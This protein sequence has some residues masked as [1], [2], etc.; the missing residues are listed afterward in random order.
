R[1][2]YCRRFGA[3]VVCCIP[4]CG[5]RFHFPC[6][7]ASGCFQDMKTLSLLCPEHIDQ[8]E[9]IYGTSACCIQCG[10]VG[11][12]REQ[13]FCTIC[14]H[15]SHGSCL[16]MPVESKPISRSGWQCPNCK[17]CQ[18]CRT[19]SDENNILVCNTCDKT[20]H[21]FCLKP[22]MATIPKNGWRCKNCRICTDCGSRTPG[23]GPSSRWHLNYSVCDS[24]YQ[25]RNKGLCCPLCGKAYRHFHNKTML[26]CMICKKFV[27]IECDPS[28][29]PD[30]MTK[31]K[32]LPQDYVCTV[33]RE[34]DPDQLM[35]EH[36]FPGLHHTMSEESMESLMTD[37]LVS[38][39]DPMLTE[40]ALS[41]GGGG[42]GRLTGSSSQESLLMGEDSSSSFDFETPERGILSPSGR[43]ESFEFSKKGR[44]KSKHSERHHHH[45]HHHYQQASTSASFQHQQHSNVSQISQSLSEKRRGPK[46]KVKIGGQVMGITSMEGSSPASQ[47]S[48]QPPFSGSSPAYSVLSMEGLS[49]EKEKEKEKE[50][51][52]E[53]PDDDGDDDDGDDH[54]N[55][56]II[57]DANDLFVMDQDICKACGSFGKDEESRMIVCTQCGQCYHP[58]CVTVT[59]TKVMLQKG[60]RCL[61]CTVCEGCGGPDDEGRL[62]LCDDCDISYHTYC[63]DPPLETVPKGN[64][65]CKW[66]V[67]CVNCGTTNPGFACHWMN[68]YTQCGPC[69]SKIYCP[70]CADSYLIDQLIIQCQQCER[71]LHCECDGLNGEDEAEMAADYGYH[72]LFCRPLTGKE[73]P[74]PPPPPPPTPPPPKEEVRTSPIPALPVAPYVAPP[75]PPRQFYMDGVYLFASGL[76][77]IQ[78]LQVTNPKKFKQQQ[79][80]QLQHQRR[81]SQL[82]DAEEGGEGLD[83]SMQEEGGDDAA[84]KR[85]PRRVFGLG[86]GGFIVR[87]RSR[88]WLAK[89]QASYEEPEDEK[90]DQA[91]GE[92]TDKPKRR[93]KIK[94][95][96]LEESFP[97]YMQEAFFGK[98]ILEQTKETTKD[99]LKQESESDGEQSSPA[100]PLPV[101]D[102]PGIPPL[103]ASAEANDAIP[104]PSGL[105]LPPPPSQRPHTSMS[106][107]ETGED[108]TGLD[109]ILQEFPENDDILSIIREELKDDGLNLDMDPVTED[110]DSEPGTDNIANMLRGDMDKGLDVDRAVGDNFLRGL[111]QIEDVED[112]FSGVLSDTP[113][114]QN[115]DS[116]VQNAGQFNMPMQMPPPQQEGLQG[117]PHPGMGALP[118]PQIPGMRP[119]M[120]GKPVQHP[121]TGLPPFGMQYNSTSNF[122]PQMGGPNFP[123]G[124]GGP[125]SVSA[126]PAPQAPGALPQGVPAPPGGPLPQWGMGPATPAAPEEEQGDGNKRTILKWEQ[127]E[128]M[129]DQ[130]TISCV[131]YVNMC[132]PDLKQKHPDWSERS[133]QIAKL[134]RKLNPEEKAPYL[135]KARKNRTSSR[136]QKAQKQVSQELQRRQE[137]QKQQDSEAMPPPPAPPPLTPGADMYH[138]G[139]NPMMSPHPGASPYPRHGWGPDDP[140]KAPG[141][142]D[143]SGPQPP[144][145]GSGGSS[146]EQVFSPNT[147]GGPG[148]AVSGGSVPSS[149]DPYAFSPQQQ[150]GHAQQATGQMDQ[151]SPSTPMRPGQVRPQ[152]RLP[153][154]QAFGASNPREEEGG[155]FPSHPSASAPGMSPRIRPGSADMFPPQG[156]VPSPSQDMMGGMAGPPRRMQGP[157][158][159]HP[160]AGAQQQPQVTDASNPMGDSPAHPGR[161]PI[162]PYAFPPGTP[163]TPSGPVDDPFLG[164]GPQGSEAYHGMRY[165]GGSPQMRHPLTPPNMNQGQSYPGSPRVPEPGFRHPLARS[166][167]MPDPYSMQM[168]GPRPQMDPSMVRNM[169]DVNPQMYRG[170]R[171]PLQHPEEGDTQGNIHRQHLRVMLGQKSKERMARKQEEAERMMHAGPGSGMGWQGQDMPEGMEGFPP[172]PQFRGPVPQG[173]IR[174]MHPGM[175]PQGQRPP[176]YPGMQRPP[177][178]EGMPGP[179]QEGMIPPDQ[180]SQFMQHM[181][182]QQQGPGGAAALGGMPPSPQQQQQQQQPQQQI[183]GMSQFMPPDSANPQHP[184]QNLSHQQ[185]LEQQRALQ[186]Q[187]QKAVSSQQQAQENIPELSGQGQVP[188]ESMFPETAA[189]SN[190]EEVPKQKAYPHWDNEVKHLSDKQ[191]QVRLEILNSKELQKIKDLKKERNFILHKIREKTKQLKNEHLDELASNIDKTSSD[192]G[193]FQAVKALNR[194]RFQNPKVHNNDRKQVSNPSQIQL[195]IANHFKSKFRDDSIHDI[196]TY[197]GRPR[198]LKSPITEKEVRASINNLNNGRAPGSDNI[199]G[200]FLKFAP[201]LI[202]NKIAKI[203]NQTFERHKDTSTKVS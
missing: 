194:K 89:R 198:K 1:C 99:L 69:H 56:L 39:D 172:R 82:E 86:V 146:G 35:E 60:W 23:S 171:L 158:Q 112:I 190:I 119:Q 135:A 167:S 33:C 170:E 120:G 117:P 155:M 61:D 90:V 186:Q 12:I 17:I 153:G 111:V 195:I 81:M 100:K 179:G 78:R 137:I 203:L 43:R 173:M 77:Q 87:Q 54:P 7:A 116:G 62:L 131:L 122:G 84:K 53:P 57:A 102:L 134:W 129:G 187:Q 113:S 8:A 121:P 51:E 25:Q 70:V 3:T 157:R 19:A 200:E 182:Q 26:P 123:P 178:V 85:K 189:K 175:G 196:D 136:V 67:M 126:G 95:S 52:P 177:H 34:T 185:Q 202:D 38:K 124:M 164:P 48:A 88:Q 142:P 130:A 71:W 76:N 28:L 143:F 103:P 2:A 154:L 63:L 27:H 58:Y 65:K 118:S 24:C 141:T 176:F 181:M 128:E 147:S 197:F 132:H 201:H 21:T 162:D 191:K 144:Q 127:E 193:M 133:K 16:S 168:G 163:Q 59:V 91:T 108:I 184:Q 104:G 151:F 45:H 125:G 150:P 30:I 149:P 183:P 66:C 156:G 75:E 174:G 152:L 5:K 55:S 42:T 188:A 10:Q 22:P 31:L 32:E 199:S 40:A 106:G 180:R 73:G 37:D 145:P 49:E 4:E 15:H 6:A 14:G 105:G 101:A 64:W 50:K 79:Q 92:K 138:D 9:S 44:Q 107:S 97:F 20:Y 80:Q 94:K 166:N 160:L 11:N 115:T 18:T 74:L 148:S 96:K 139:S 93:R 161:G 83:Q 72:C 109:D 46:I 13:L 36:N 68:N 140:M 169:P 41:G 192:G 29:N 47:H 165:P 114:N 110:K 159:G 98:G